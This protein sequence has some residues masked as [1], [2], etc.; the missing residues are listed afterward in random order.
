MTEAAPPDVKRRRLSA[1][2]GPHQDARRLADLPSGILAHAASFLAAPSRSLFAIALD[3]IVTPNEER[4]SAIVGNQWDTLDFGEIEQDLAKKLSDY[5]VVRVLQCIDAVNKLKRLKLTNCTNIIGTGLVPLRGSL[6][7]EQIDLSV[8][9]DNQGPDI[10][11]VP[12]IS[13]EHIFPILDSIIEREDCA[14]MHLHFPKVWR[15]EPST[16][17]E[18]HAFILR[19]N[20]MR[21]GREEINCLK[22]HSLLPSTGDEWIETDTDADNYYGA[23]W[24]TCYGCL[25]HYCYRCD[26]EEGKKKLHVCDTCQRDYCEDCSKMN[27][28]YGCAHKIC[29]DCYN[30]KCAKCNDEFCL[31]CVEKGES[32]HKCEYCNKV[33]CHECSEDDTGIHICHRCNTCNTKCCKDCLLQRYR[34]EQLQ[35]T[36]CIN[37]S[38]AMD[39]SLERKQLQE[40]NEQLK[41]EVEALKR[42]VKELKSLITKSS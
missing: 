38:V 17:S 27:H 6:V 30:Y 21:A 41:I 39:E 23:Y 4:S 24:N 32:V 36:K 25:K 11:P 20:E 42:E 16:D 10:N 18:F 28:C 40:E 31:E 9:Y 2:D 34:Q 13:C 3:E 8:V 19:Y 35:C 33:Y 5:D 26:D 14:L 7:I 29:N 1:V 37:R 22:C 15:R 12:Q